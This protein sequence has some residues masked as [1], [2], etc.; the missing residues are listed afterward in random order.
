[1]AVVSLTTILRAVWVVL[2]LIILSLAFALYSGP[3]RH[4]MF[5]LLEVTSEDNGT[6]V[7]FGALSM[8]SLFLY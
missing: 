5:T 2:T 3:H 6:T 8:I 7:S 4:N 1:M